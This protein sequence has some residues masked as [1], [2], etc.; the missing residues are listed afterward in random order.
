[1]TIYVPWPKDRA[2]SRGDW[3]PAA[4]TRLISADDHLTEAVNL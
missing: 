4:G 2:L 3:T 1:M